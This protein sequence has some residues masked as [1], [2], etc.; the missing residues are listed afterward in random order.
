METT[1]R[2]IKNVLDHAPGVKGYALIG[3]MAMGAW[4]QGRTTMDL[5]ILVG[6]CRT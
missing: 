5:D 6:T 3:A 1:L 4:V 2:I